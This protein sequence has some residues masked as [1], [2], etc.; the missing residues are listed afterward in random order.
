MF[1]QIRNSLLYVTS[2]LDRWAIVLMFIVCIVCSVLKV[3][4]ACERK[5]LL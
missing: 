3:I 4:E 5:L 1:R 2:H